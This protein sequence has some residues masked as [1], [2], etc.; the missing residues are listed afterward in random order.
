MYARH[1][2]RLLSTIG[3][4]AFVALT[5]IPRWRITA[6]APT[7]R[8]RRLPHPMPACPR[9]SLPAPS[10]NW[11]SRTSSP[12]RPFA[13]CH[14][15]STMAVTLRSTARPRRAAHGRTRRSDRTQ[16]RQRRLVRNEHTDSLPC[17]DDSAS[18]ATPQTEVEGTLTMVHADDFANGRGRY[19]LVVVEDNGHATPMN[20]AVTPST[21]QLRHARRRIRLGRG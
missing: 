20:L 9:S 16:R 7:P 14:C 19:N 13:T 1:V 21:L 8:S 15:V 3:A 17:A 11:S 18:R 10:R 6:S 2:R 4:A 5:A 12:V